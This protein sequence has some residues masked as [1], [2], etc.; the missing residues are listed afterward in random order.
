MFIE[1]F[2]NFYKPN[3]PDTNEK[4]KS[5]VLVNEVKKIVEKVIKARKEYVLSNILNPKLHN[6][7]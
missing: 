7:D 2:L 6:L 3:V 1:I 5:F 4:S